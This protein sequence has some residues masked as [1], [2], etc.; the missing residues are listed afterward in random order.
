MQL[1]ITVR[2]RDLEINS[3]I[4]CKSLLSI[5]VTFLLQVQ[6][7]TGMIKSISDF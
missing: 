4:V 3:S 7:N 2:L 6:T 5:I 1:E